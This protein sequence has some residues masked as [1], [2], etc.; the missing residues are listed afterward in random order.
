V[1]PRRIRN[2]TAEATA[3]SREIIMLIRQVAPK[4]LDEY[5]VGPDSAATLLIA[6]GDNPE[7][8]TSE[9][10]FAALCGVCRPASAVRFGPGIWGRVSRRTHPPARLVSQ[11]RSGRGVVRL[12]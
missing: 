9:A 10:A 2:L 5:G 4:L 7:R 12:L 8:L 3:L 11:V 1:E 6:A